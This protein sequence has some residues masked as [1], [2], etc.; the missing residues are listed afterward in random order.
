MLQFCCCVLPTFAD[1][2][3][4][5]HTRTAAGAHLL[6]STLL[7]PPADLATIALRQ[8]AVQKLLED[9]EMA[10]SLRAV[11]DKLPR[12]LDKYGVMQGFGLSLL[13]K[14]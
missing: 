6:K 12:D 4:L 7:Q 9:G 8:Q 2:R 1:R 3:L 14:G 13:G 5:D 11:L 10:E